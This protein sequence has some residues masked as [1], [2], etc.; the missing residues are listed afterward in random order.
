MPLSMDLALAGLNP[1]QRLPF[2]DAPLPDIYNS[3]FRQLC[4]AYGGGVTGLDFIS[5]LPEI[6]I[7]DKTITKDKEEGGDDPVEPIGAKEGHQEIKDK[8][9]GGDGTTDLTSAVKAH[10]GITEEENAKD[11]AKDKAEEKDGTT[12]PL[13]AV[14]AHRGSSADSGQAS[15]DTTRIGDSGCKMKVDQPEEASWHFNFEWDLDKAPWG[16]LTDDDDTITS[17]ASEDMRRMG[18]A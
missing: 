8:A 1:T 4:G 12:N 2:L 11:E 15:K 6:H 10:Q 3:L 17:V 9:E 16:M 13:E 7:T 14:G 18:K 5:A